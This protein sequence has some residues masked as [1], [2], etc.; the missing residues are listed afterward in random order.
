MTDNFR[1]VE[2]EAHVETTQDSLDR[3]R[4]EVAQL[5]ASRMRLAVAD[6]DERRR[7]ERALH[8]GQQQRLVTFAV[9]LQLARELLD[10]D[11]ARAKA[12]LEE[13]AS[14][15]E[16]ALDEAAALAHHI[17]PPLL[18]TGGLRPALRAA[19]VATGVSPAIDVRVSARLPPEVAGAVYF[20]CVELLGPVRART[21]AVYE[22]EGAVLFDVAG[23]GM[24]ESSRSDVL[25]RVRDRVEAL[26][27]EISVSSGRNGDSRIHGSV[28]LRR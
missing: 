26:G 23:D 14:D 19:S 2:Q 12:L 4:E 6:D 21:V 18:E 5:R 8:D 20:G 25:L 10:S 9:N 3:L 17:Y 11:P 22:D 1:S 15:V 28:P 13:M 27:G 16:R 7:I 24:P